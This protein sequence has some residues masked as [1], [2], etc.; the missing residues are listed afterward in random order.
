MVGI[1]FSTISGSDKFYQLLLWIL[2]ESNAR[3]A[4]S[5]VHISVLRGIRVNQEVE[6]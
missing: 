5:T 3:P 1:S 2:K 6:S 4:P